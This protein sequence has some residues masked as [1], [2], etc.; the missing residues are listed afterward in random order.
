MKIYLSKNTICKGILLI[1]SVLS[2]YLV[3]AQT[4][5]EQTKMD[6]FVNGLMGKMTLEEKLGQLNLVTT[7]YPIQDTLICFTTF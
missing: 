1:V 2:F 7:S 5:S 6:A 3:S 4:K